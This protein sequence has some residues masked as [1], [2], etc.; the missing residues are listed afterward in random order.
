MRRLGVSF[1]QLAASSIGSQAIGFAVLAFVARRIGPS[2]LGTYGFAIN[3]VAYFALPLAG[4]AILAIRDIAQRPAA[5]ARITGVVLPLYV[6]YAVLA[7]VAIYFLAPVIAP[8]HSAITMLRIVGLS[9]TVT[10]VT[11]DWLLVGIKAFRALAAA[12]LLGQVC[13]AIAVVLFMT[14]GLNGAYR[15]AALNVL[16]LI[17]TM[18]AIGVVGVRR[19]GW[20]KVSWS[21]RATSRLLTRSRHFVLST[22]MIKIYFSA[23]FVLLGFL[24]T[25]A[26][27]GQYVVA[28]KLPQ[29]ILGLSSLWVSVM[30]PHAATQERNELRRQVG[31]FTTF[32]ASL[33]I[34]LCVGVFILARPLMTTLFGAEYA[35][36][37][38]AFRLLTVAAAIGTVDS[39]IGQVLMAVGHE[40]TFSMGVTIGAAVN[41]ILNLAFIPW[42]GPVGAALATIAAEAGVLWFM[43]RHLARV[44]GRPKLDAP[45]LG[46]AV[47]SSGVMAGALLVAAALPVFIRVALGGLVFLAAA[48]VT[49]VIKRSDLVRLRTRPAV[50]SRA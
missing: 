19:A 6:A 40:R 37:A 25:P 42:L 35:P 16:G 14:S 43:V 1:L 21:I 20:P 46:A 22:V 30:Y 24:S 41:L 23:D 28:Y 45:R 38:T 48:A 10:L 15:Y 47:V 8:T 18:L 33:A 32:S 26:K 17:I 4:V 36:A 50:D 9:T 34:P 12:T 13:Y 3:T 7:Y 27:L 11:Y 31:V 49:G 29:A 44:I 39:N 2:N 5:A